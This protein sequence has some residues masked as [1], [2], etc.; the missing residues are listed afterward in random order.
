[1]ASGFE[2]LRPPSVTKTTLLEKMS[3]F[4]SEVKQIIYVSVSMFSSETIQ[5][6]HKRNQISKVVQL[7]VVEGNLF[8][9][10]KQC[11]GVTNNLQSLPHYVPVCAAF[12]PI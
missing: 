4:V 8:S 5:T 10:R 9:D 1:M 12:F 6:R 11:P 3:A 2:D 7:V